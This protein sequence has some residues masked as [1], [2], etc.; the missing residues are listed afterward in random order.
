M[1]RTCRQCHR[2]FVMSGWP[3][4]WM[5]GLGPRGH[6]GIKREETSRLF[7]T[8]KHFQRLWWTRTRWVVDSRWSEGVGHPAVSRQL[9]A[10]K[11]RCPTGATAAC[12]DTCKCGWSNDE[13]G[14]RPGAHLPSTHLP[15]YPTTRRPST[16]TSLPVRLLGPT[17]LWRRLSCLLLMFAL[18]IVVV[19]IAVDI[20]LFA[21]RTALRE[22]YV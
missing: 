3:G 6:T 5:G 16:I 10:S 9:D 4:W 12:P 13:M 22:I 21:Y 14:T 19:V 1:R 7:A 17:I 11:A 8:W 2:T 18:I 20:V 15:I